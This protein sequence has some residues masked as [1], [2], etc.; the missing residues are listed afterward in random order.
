MIAGMHLAY[1]DDSG[2]SKN[3]ATLTALLVEAPHWAGLLE[4]WIEGRRAVQREFGVRRHAELHA[5]DL[6]KGRREFCET[7]DQ[8]AAFGKASRGAT[9]RI[10]LNSLSAYGHFNVVTVGSADVVK[11]RLYAR[12]VDYL[13]D[14]AKT[15]DTLLMIFYDGHQGFPK[16]E[17]EAS[18]EELAELW[19][20][21][22]RDATPYRRVHRE[23]DIERRY[24]I[25]DVIMRT[26]ATAS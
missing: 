18:P 23:L 4:A 16:V 1:V 10:M 26:V 25:E 12:F 24:V 15:N 19:D 22:L 17:G 3:G 14:W 2:D 6:Y 8:E 5:L 13:E 21:G 20:V 7:K 11:P 9:G